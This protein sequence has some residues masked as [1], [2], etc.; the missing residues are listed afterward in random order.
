MK[1]I[2]AFLLALVLCLGLTAC[3]EENKYADLEK[4]LDEGRYGDAMTYILSLQSSNSGSVPIWGVVQPG[5]NTYTDEDLD[6]D[7]EPSA[8]VLALIDELMGEWVISSESEEQLQKIIF[9][10]DGTCT[11]DGK[12][13]TWKRE[14]AS[15]TEYPQ[16]SNFLSIWEGETERYRV[17]QPVKKNSGALTFSI[18]LVDGIVIGYQGYGYIKPENYEV[19]ELTMDNWQEYFEFTEK[20][21]HNTN[22]FGDISSVGRS[23]YFK[24]KETYF[25]RLAASRKSSGSVEL[26]YTTFTYSA[27]TNKDG[28]E[29]TVGEFFREGSGPAQNIFS[30]ST[31]HDG[32]YWGTSYG[33]G[34]AWASEYNYDVPAPD[35]PC[36]CVH[37][38]NAQVLRI[39]GTLYLVKAQ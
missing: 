19:I 12:E 17:T 38:K 24:L 22:A 23:Y 9:R 32:T 28:T 4:M 5:D 31:C 15:I 20:P 1:R 34:D 13:M 3:T 7:K 21:Y 33:R 2:F 18:G 29:Y 25:N 16:M 11:V 36:L 6:A 37:T 8:E 10:A 27:H 26:S 39:Q 14:A 30:L 35:S